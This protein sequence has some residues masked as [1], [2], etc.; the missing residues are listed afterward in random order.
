M[1]NDYEY[2]VSVMETQFRQRAYD[3][4]W[5]RLGKIIDYD[6]KYTYQTSS[7]SSV[8]LI[9]EKWITVAVYDYIME[10]VE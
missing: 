2:G 4:K 9:P 7:G 1:K 3:G 5:E 6:N 10:I 8:A